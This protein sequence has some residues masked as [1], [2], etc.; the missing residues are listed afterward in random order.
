MG[1]MPPGKMVNTITLIATAKADLEIIN[2][3]AS[4]AAT[5]CKL[6]TGL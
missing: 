4:E 5:A 3:V 2:I 1:I 6:V